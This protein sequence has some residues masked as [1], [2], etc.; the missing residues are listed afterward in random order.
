MKPVSQGPIDSMFA[1]G[2]W[3]DMLKAQRLPEYK[4]KCLVMLL[5]LSHVQ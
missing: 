2:A 1:S 5:K 3:E 4:R